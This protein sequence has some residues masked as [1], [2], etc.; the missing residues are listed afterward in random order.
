MRKIFILS[1]YVTFL[2]FPQI[3]QCQSSDTKALIENKTEKFYTKG[4]AKA[5]GINISIEYPSSWKGAEGERPNIVQKF[6]ADA[7]D[8]ITK[9]C[10][11]AINDMPKILSLLPAEDLSKEAFSEQALQDMIPPEAVF[12]DG[13]QTKYDGQIGAWIVYSMNMERAGMAVKMYTLQ[14]MFIYAGKMINVQCSVGG[15]AQMEDNIYSAFTQYFPLFQQIGN[16][17]IIH[18]KWEKPSLKR[19]ETSAAKIAF[20]EYWWL[21]LI[22]SAL[23]TWG[24]GL[25]PP[26]LIR[27]VF[28]RRPISKV[29]ALIIAGIFWCINLVLFIAL[30]SQSKTHFA[31]FLVAAASYYIL[32]AGHKKVTKEGK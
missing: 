21:S 8:G 2:F 15:L 13:K 20:G 29:A 32:R 6:S 9:G 14:Q 27:Y 1:I 10:M 7:S 23:L 25:L 5:K 31:V 22:V 17:I 18:D 19:Q 28:M 11:I 12:I 30:G 16:S 4:H 26:V 3:A 24:L